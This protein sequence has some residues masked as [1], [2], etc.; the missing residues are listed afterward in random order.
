[1][2]RLGKRRLQEGLL[3]E[4]KEN[5]RLESWEDEGFL[6]P[7]NPS[8]VEIS[9]EGDL[10]VVKVDG[11][12]VEAVKIEEGDDLIQVVEEIEADYMEGH[13]A[14]KGRG[15]LQEGIKI[16]SIKLLVK[17]IKDSIMVGDSE[18]F[19]TVLDNLNIE[20]GVSASNR[21]TLTK[22]FKEMIQ[23]IEDLD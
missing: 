23:V 17:S 3:L 2:K 14:S 10:A 18:H 19:K 6:G 9:V 5:R 15:K 4:G 8:P 7:V 16:N 21:I 11:Q 13:K 1:M 12:E 20:E 22:L